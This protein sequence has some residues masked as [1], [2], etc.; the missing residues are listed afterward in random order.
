MEKRPIRIITAVAAFD[1]H[2]ASVLALNRALLAGSHPVEVIYLG[3][4]MTSEQI[5]EAVLQEG[6]DAVA[7]SS[8]NGGHLQFFPH[9]VRRLRDKGMESAL[10]F[11]GGGGTILPE[12]AA[13][14]E[15]SGVE[16]IYAP[17]WSLD[18]IASD[19]SR[20][21]DERL[22]HAPAAP[23][24]PGPAPPDP[25]ELSRLLS[26]AEQ[27]GDADF[28]PP[29]R[30]S[31]ETAEIAKRPNDEPSRVVA[32]TGDGGSGKSTLIDD[33]VGHFLER[34]PDKRVAILAN[35]PSLDT[36]RATPPFSPTGCA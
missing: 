11:G 6:G 34:F 36:G 4:N 28:A 32:I 9:L 31:A 14:L 17:G 7:V 23:P 21:I 19:M 33:L 30:R 16:K 10:V 8:Y 20:R 5:A 18:D 27:G 35:D 13:T 25:L 15:A 29:D 26:R 1:G 2:D 3:F 22:A 12:D 24:S